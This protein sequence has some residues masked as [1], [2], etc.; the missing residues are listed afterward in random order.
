MRGGGRL[1]AASLALDQGAE[2]DTLP[3]TSTEVVTTVF[4]PTTSMVATCIYESGVWSGV[5]P[6]NAGPCPLSPEV[7]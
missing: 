5:T 7:P 1:T 2:T 4:T 3:E 6:R